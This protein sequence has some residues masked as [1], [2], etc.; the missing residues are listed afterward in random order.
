MYKELSSPPLS[1]AC[2]HAFPSFSH[3]SALL[4]LPLFCLPP[5][6][7]PFFLPHSILSPAFTLLSHSSS[8][9]P[10][11]CSSLSLLPPPFSSP[12]SRALRAAPAAAPLLAAWLPCALPILGGNFE[13]SSHE[14]SPYD[15]RIHFSQRSQ[16]FLKIGKERELL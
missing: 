4:R 7:A 5:V 10:A 15:M 6:L 14:I 8:P 12:S 16:T 9:P 13:N 2:L 1:F 11:P 3:R